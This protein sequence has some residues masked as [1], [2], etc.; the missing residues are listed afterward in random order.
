MSKTKDALAGVIENRDTY[1]LFT[2]V[3]RLRFTDAASPNA[4]E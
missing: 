3:T 2:G 1:L 4:S